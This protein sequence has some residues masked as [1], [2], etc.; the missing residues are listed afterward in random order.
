MTVYSTY[1]HTHAPTD[2][3]TN[4]LTYIKGLEGFLHSPS[5]M[6]AMTLATWEGLGKDGS[7]FSFKQ[8]LTEFS[9]NWK[10]ELSVSVLE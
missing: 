10:E 7:C 9:R 3:P 8:F 2:I 6:R 1:I 4:Q 5:A